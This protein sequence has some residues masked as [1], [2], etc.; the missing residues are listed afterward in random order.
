[1]IVDLLVEGQIDEMAGRKIIEFCDY[2]LG[3]VYGRQG[4]GYIKAKISGFSVRA[5][6]GNPIL[7]LVDFMD[8][9]LSCPPAIADWV[10]QSNTQL[11]LRAVVNE[12]ES[13]L[14]ADREAIAEY[15]GVSVVHVPQQPEQL[16]DPK[17]ALVNVARHS[18]RKTIRDIIP[19][20]GM[21]GVVGMGYTDVMSN[22]IQNHWNVARAAKN[23]PSLKRCVARLQ[24][25]G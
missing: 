24:A 5:Q 2:R 19:P 8:T 13:W 6:Y 20:Q 14:L 25:L 21:S 17:Q 12:M 3:I 4:F 9:G 16:D 7:A 15:F 22:F 1:M 18:R 11:I 23:A 10:L